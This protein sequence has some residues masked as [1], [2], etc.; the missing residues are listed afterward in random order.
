MICI[1]ES[2][3]VIFVTN[4]ATGSVM[5]CRKVICY[6]TSCKLQVTSCKLR[7]ASCQLQIDMPVGALILPVGQLHI[8]VVYTKSPVDLPC[9]LENDYAS[10]NINLPDGT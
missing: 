9:Q 6:Y 5:P 7:V 8:P 4:G 1:T 2:K 10:W 3:S